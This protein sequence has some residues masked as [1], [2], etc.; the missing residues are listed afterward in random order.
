M[1][2]VLLCLL[3]LPDLGRNQLTRYTLG[4]GGPGQDVRKRKVESGFVSPSSYLIFRYTKSREH[5]HVV[6]MPES[7]LETG[8]YERSLTGADVRISGRHFVDTNGRVLELRGANVSSC[9][10]VYVTFRPVLNHL[11]LE[12]KLHRIY[13]FD[14]WLK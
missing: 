9:S 3:D 6:A 4:G 7:S 11:S 5:Q 13:H 12:A 1:A 8:K 14:D 2:V 10:K